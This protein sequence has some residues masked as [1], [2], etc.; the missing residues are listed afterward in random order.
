MERE[1]RILPCR[2]GE[3]HLKL[4]FTVM[5]GGWFIYC[6]TCGAVMGECTSRKEAIEYWN[7]TIMEDYEYE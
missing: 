6:P 5:S 1:D 4:S 2:C 3:R 7:L